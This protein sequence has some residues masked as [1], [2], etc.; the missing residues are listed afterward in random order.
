MAEPTPP[1]QEGVPEPVPAEVG[2]V[3]GEQRDVA[4]R[5]VDILRSR[6][7]EWGL[8]GPREP[9]RLWSRHVLNSA[10][11]A[12]LFPLGAHVVD[13][14]SGAGL[15]G[16]PLALARPDLGMTLL[17]PLQRRAEFLQL[18]VDELEL[19]E[20]V[21]VVR[22]RAEDHDEVYDVVTGRAVGALSKM[23]PWCEPL[24]ADDGQMILLKGASAEDEVRAAQKLLSRARLSAEVLSVRAHPSSEPTTAVRLRRR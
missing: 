10:A 17:E 13:V 15:P 11:V 1:Q 8:L 9:G 12:S 23:V 21:R 5:Y 4:A 7:V 20:R 18:A 22:A 19:E 6:G 3:F 16:I 24:V 14:G 2:A